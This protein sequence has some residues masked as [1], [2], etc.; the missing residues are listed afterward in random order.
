M[1]GGRQRGGQ[2]HDSSLE[3][4]LSKKLTVSYSYLYF[5]GGHPPMASAHSPPL[6]A[7]PVVPAAMRAEDGVQLDAEFAGERWDSSWLK[8]PCVTWLKISTAV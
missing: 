3:S 6:A 8:D 4:C 5:D 2:L 1:I 7:D